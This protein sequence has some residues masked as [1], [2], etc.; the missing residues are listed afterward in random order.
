MG[1]R[2]LLQPVDSHSVVQTDDGLRRDARH[3]K[4]LNPDPR[5]CTRVTAGQTCCGA[6][7][8]VV[9]SAADTLAPAVTDSSWIV[10]SGRPGATP[11]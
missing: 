9:P 5:G 8:R 11:L 2:R 3:V 4:Y 10:E 1:V 6:D 7:Y